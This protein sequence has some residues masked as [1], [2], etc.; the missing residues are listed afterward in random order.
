[1]S[2]YLQV[3]T[4]VESDEDARRL[5]RGVVEGRH[6]ACVQIVGPI[7]SVY[8]WQG[9]LEEAQEWQL[10]VK[11]TA[12]AYPSLEAY[13]KQHHS[14]ETPEIIATAIVTGSPEYLAWIAA[15]ATSGGGSA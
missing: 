12:D 4:T 9:E 3:A 8:W 15:E 6:G 14:Y 5:A 10:L 11:T 7:R 2:D 13:L 1:M